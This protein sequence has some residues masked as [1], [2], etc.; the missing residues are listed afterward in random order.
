MVLLFPGHIPFVG[1]KNAH[2]VAGFV[3]YILR[4][5]VCPSATILFSFF[6]N[7]NTVTPLKVKVK[8]YYSVLFPCRR[9]SSS[10]FSLDLS[11][12]KKKKEKKD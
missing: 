3:Q 7:Q 5:S 10:V 6:E 9:K 8:M 11:Y 4:V 12:W 1:P 2:P